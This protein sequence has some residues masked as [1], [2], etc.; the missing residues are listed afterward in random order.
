MGSVDLATPLVNLNSTTTRPALFTNNN[1]KPDKKDVS[2]FCAGLNDDDY[3][4]SILNVYENQIKDLRLHI[5]REKRIIKEKEEFSKRQQTSTNE[6]K[7]IKTQEEKYF[8]KNKSYQFASFLLDKFE[9]K[10]LEAKTNTKINGD[11]QLADLRNGINC[12]TTLT[13]HQL[14]FAEVFTHASLPMIYGPDYLAN[15]L[16]IKK[17]NAIE[18][19]NQ[20]CLICCPRR[21]GKTKIT[22]VYV[23][24]Y[25]RFIA[26]A[27][28]TVFSPGKRQSGLFMEEVKKALAHLENCGFYFDRVKGADN[29]ERF[30]LEIN[31]NKRQ[32]TVLPSKESVN[33]IL[34][35]HPLIYINYRNFFL[36][37]QTKNFSIS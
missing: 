11:K 23:A 34:L 5:A 8:A 19:L 31:G 16:R 26:D 32:L 28:C 25:L 33:C 30:A 20:F 29:Q 18:E 2:S 1:F 10:K 15:E 6:N 9:R 24:C 37:K 22:S 7:K 13:P 17:Q 35:T 12:F 36:D 3:N 4:D 27:N 21:F 14:M